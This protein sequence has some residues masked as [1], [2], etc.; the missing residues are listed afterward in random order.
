MRTWTFILI[1]YLC[2]SLQIGLGPLWMLP[3][4]GGV[5]PSLLLT[6]AM[7]IALWAPPM[8]VI[9][10][11]LVLGLLTDIAYPLPV[12]GSVQD[13]VVLGPYA[14]A[15]MLA[16]WLGLKAR[17]LVFRDSYISMAAMVFLL[18]LVVHLLAVAL[19]N[20]RGLSV[21]VIPWLANSPIPGWRTTDQ[22]MVRFLEVVYSAIIA[23]P[24]GALL[25]RSLKWWNFENQRGPMG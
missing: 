14:L 6:L 21:S 13:A 11:C 5:K 8:R 4:M 22:L 18:G 3:W 1:A 20:L 23:L 25:M 2:L 12:Q 24:V 15:Y 19:F 16:G 7:F 17:A 9:W 10:S